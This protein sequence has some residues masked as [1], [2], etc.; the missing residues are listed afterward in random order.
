MTSSGK[1]GINYTFVAS[2]SDPD[3]SDLLYKWDWG[4]GNYSDWL[5]T[6][7]TTYAWSYEANF[8]V[9]V[10]AQDECG[11]EST[12]SDPLPIAVPYSYDHAIPH[13]LKVLFQRVPLVFSSIRHLIGY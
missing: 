11:G 12:W 1:P 7:S 2:S 9:R 8:E 5:S 13:F 10:M 6:A 4:D 3:G